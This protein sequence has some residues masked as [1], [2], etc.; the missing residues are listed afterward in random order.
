MNVEGVKYNHAI[1]HDRSMMTMKRMKEYV[2]KNPKVAEF[3]EGF[4]KRDEKMLLL[5]M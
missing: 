5:H 4:E 2:L 3:L 1:T